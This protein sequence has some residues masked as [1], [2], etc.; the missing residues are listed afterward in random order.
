[1]DSEEVGSTSTLTG[2]GFD[3]N[4]LPNS[5][6]PNFEIDGGSFIGIN[7][8]GEESTNALSDTTSGFLGLL[9][10]DG[11][12]IPQVTSLQVG[13]SSGGDVFLDNL[14]VVNAP[15]SVPEPASFLGT[16]AA[17]FGL[18]GFRRRQ[19]S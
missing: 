4:I 3:F 16:L 2:I 18:I 14:T 15:T 5:F 8:L 12:F 10:T 13:T 7:I 6:D 9:S 1:M 17:A 11:F 19:R